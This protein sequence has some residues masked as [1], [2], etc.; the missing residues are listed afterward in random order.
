MYI[1][2]IATGQCNLIKLRIVGDVL[3]GT[4]R[5]PAD[6]KQVRTGEIPGVKPFGDGGGETISMLEQLEVLAICSI[7]ELQILVLRLAKHVAVASWTTGCI[8]ADVSQGLARSKS[9]CWRSF[10]QA[11]GT[12]TRWSSSICSLLSGSKSS[13]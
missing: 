13:I 6:F 9:N 3:D 10:H 8:G 5:A 4:A 11:I 1:H 12:A 2:K 7:Q